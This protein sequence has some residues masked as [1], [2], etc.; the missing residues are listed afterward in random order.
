MSTILTLRS[1]AMFHVAAFR[2][3]IAASHAAQDYAGRFTRGQYPSH[4]PPRLWVK[5]DPEAGGY[6]IT[7]NEFDFVASKNQAWLA[8]VEDEKRAREMNK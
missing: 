4:Q 7:P 2:D 3:N 6:C 1:Q 5:F 8:L